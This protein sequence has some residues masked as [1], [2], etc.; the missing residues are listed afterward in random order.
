[1]HMAKD[2][3]FANTLEQHGHTMLAGPSITLK[4]CDKWQIKKRQTILGSKP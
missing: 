1:M 4:V 3:F 2:L